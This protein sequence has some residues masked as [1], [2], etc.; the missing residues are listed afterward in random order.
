[1]LKK[2]ESGRSMIEM[3]GVLAIIGVLSVGGIAGYTTAM[4]SHRANEI[5]NGVSTLYMMGLA[6][7]VGAGDQPMEMDSNMLPSGCT[8]IRY[9]GD[10]STVEVSITDATD[11]ATV[12]NKLGDKAGEC[13]AEKTDGAY[14]LTVTLGET[15]GDVAYDCTN[16]NGNAGDISC[17]LF[18][19]GCYQTYKCEDNGG[20]MGIYEWQ[21]SGPGYCYID[22]DCT[23][24]VEE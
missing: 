5:I 7:N 18:Y 24:Q 9:P 1:M 3:L 14:V 22:S 17:Q 13:P 16:P 8:K 15:A 4:R 23:T 11:C 19:A 20:D 6:S 2:F 12:K 10:Q 21:Q